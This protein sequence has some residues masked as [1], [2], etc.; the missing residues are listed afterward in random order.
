MINQMLF[1]QSSDALSQA[2]DVQVLIQNMDLQ[3]ELW[4]INQRY[5]Q[6][7]LTDVLNYQNLLLERNNL[8]IRRDGSLSL[9]LDAAL[10]LVQNDIAN[11]VAGVWST[12]NMALKNIMSFVDMNRVG[13]SF[14][15]FS[16]RMKLTQIS[17]SL[18][19]KGVEFFDLRYNIE[20]ISHS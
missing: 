15:S 18:V 7:T 5:N 1:K 6:G 9:A 8:I 11:N 13:Y 3:I 20:K 16:N 19:T 10:M 12:G 17:A 4:Q 14:V 2:R